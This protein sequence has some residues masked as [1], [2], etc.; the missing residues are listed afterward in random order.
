MVMI[1]DFV[2]KQKHAL[3]I[4]GICTPSSKEYFVF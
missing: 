1:V 2:I 4:F 3:G